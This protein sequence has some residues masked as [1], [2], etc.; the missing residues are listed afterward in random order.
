MV[1][2]GADASCVSWCGVGVVVQDKAR[3]K[4]KRERKK[5]R[6]HMAKVRVRQALGMNH[7]VRRHKSII[8]FHYRSV[9][10]R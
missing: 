4:K 2:S 10:E 6:E 9:Q 8:Y 1:G 5:E 7:Q 3:A